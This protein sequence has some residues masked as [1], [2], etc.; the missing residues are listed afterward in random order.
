MATVLL[1]SRREPSY[2]HCFGDGD[3]RESVSTQHSRLARAADSDNDGISR[4]RGTP[5][6]RVQHSS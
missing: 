2:C 4:T 1:P 5:P 6:H 3:S